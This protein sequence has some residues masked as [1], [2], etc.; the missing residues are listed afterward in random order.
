M[1]VGFILFESHLSMSMR[2]HGQSKRHVLS[3]DEMSV[4][5]SL[6][7]QQSTNQLVSYQPRK[8][9]SY[10]VAGWVIFDLGRDSHLGRTIPNCKVIFRRSNRRGSSG[11]VRAK[12]QDMTTSHALHF[13]SKS[14]IVKILV[15]LLHKGILRWILYLKFFFWIFHVNVKPEYSDKCDKLS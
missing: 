2:C 15:C 5:R 13:R 6:P 7:C 3:V 8:T 11:L 12:K 4:A 14:I 1:Y 9:D 10:S